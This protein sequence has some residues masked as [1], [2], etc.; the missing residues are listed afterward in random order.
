MK[1]IRTSGLL[2]AA[3]RLFFVSEYGILCS[4]NEFELRADF[5]AEK[6]KQ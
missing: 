3:D 2:S 1:Q 6:E 5:G 4:L